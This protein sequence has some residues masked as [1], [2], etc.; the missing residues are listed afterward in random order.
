M[1]SSK[2]FKPSNLA[3]S[4]AIA[5]GL[6]LPTGVVHA[7][8]VLLEEVIVTAQKREESNQDVPFT[9]TALSNEM[10]EKKGIQNTQDLL[11]QTPGIAGFESPGA[12]GTT[13]LTVR[14]VQ[15]G[16][17]ANLSVDPAIGIYIDG[18]FLGKQVAS[19]MDVAELERV[20]ILRGPQGTLYGRNSVGG[21]INFISKKPTGEFD[22]KIKAGLG[23]YGA[24]NFRLYTN[25]PAI[26][27]VGEGIGKLSTSLAYQ[28]RD[29]DPLYDNVDPAKPGFNSLDRS[30]WRFAAKLDVTD[31]FSAE[32]TYDKNEL[33]ELN[34][35]ERIVGFNPLD[36][37]G[38]VTVIGTLKGMLQG[39]QY[40][41][42]QTGADPRIASRW[43]PS[44]QATIAAYEQVEA[45]GRGRATKGAGDVPTYTT[46]ENDG[47][48]LTLTWDMENSEFKSITAK[49]QVSTYVTGDLEDL[50]SSLDANGIG[51][52]GD[53]VHL[54]LGQI[55]SGTID[56]TGGQGVGVAYPSP[57]VDAVWNGIDTL[58]A[59]QTVQ[60][61]YSDYEQFSQE[62]Q[63]V[64]THG[65][66]DY[67]TGLYY[68]DDESNY[69]RYAIFAAPLSG[70]G[71]QL[72]DLQAEAW[73]AY[74]QTTFKMSESSPF[75]FTAGIRYTEEDKD[76][77]WNYPA[78]NTPFGAVPDQVA[79]D[80]E[81]YDDISYTLSIAYAASENTN[82]Y[83]RYATGY[84]SGG[85]NGEMFGSAAFYEEKVKSWEV[86]FK[87]TSL[88]GR[89]RTN[90][91]VY[92][93]TWEDI[94]TAKIET[95]ANTGKVTSGLVNAGKATRWGAELEMVGA[96]TENFL[97]GFS[98]SYLHGDFDE[99]PDICGTSGVCI[100]GGK[101]ARRANSPDNQAN[102]FADVT[103]ARLENGELTA[104]VNASWQDA[105][106]ENAMWSNLI[107][108]DAYP[109]QNPWG[110]MSE[111]TIIDA[112]ISLQDVKVGNGT[113][114]V[115]LWG[116][117]LSDEDYPLYSINFGAMNIITE[118][119]GDPRTYGVDV[120]YQF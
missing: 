44:L 66:F 10:M 95:D 24:T 3:L 80:S 113:L 16:Q 12:K 68:F 91:A 38:D 18:V 88:D 52:Y 31:N 41:Q 111:R 35:L 62:F 30:A 58:G 70:D 107:A 50:D 79:A 5:A 110:M 85:F 14:G 51:A 59:N 7:G 60:D 114:A 43:I 67:A 86:G 99:Y 20:E 29:R 90:G 1:H 32:Y 97:M 82:L 6:G 17:P 26:G 73:A 8:N 106:Y 27:A 102:I 11:L 42:T 117:N 77:A 54:T 98:Y 115:S 25:L 61:T 100:D 53:L 78:Y 105:Y 118:N 55:Y 57:Y 65:L 4:I 9:I 89:L 19:A 96:L 28:Q 49:R 15:A 74:A 33:D 2:Q 108:N 92:G 75:S 119:Y 103:L 94:Q 69:R 72:Y 39:A 48:T 22:M 21:A 64:G 81:S 34:N 101:N 104:F 47:H 40:W 83:G 13:T 109:R 87:N 120:T 36:L 37:N 71:S 23:N 56:A 63:L 84:R 93:Y 46:A 112:N 45:T 76:V 116:K